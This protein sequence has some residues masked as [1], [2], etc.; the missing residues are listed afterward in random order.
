MMV[1]VR[2]WLSRLI[3]GNVAPSPSP[4]A[5]TAPPLAPSPRPSHNSGAF[6]G[7][8]SHYRPQSS[9]PQFQPYERS[10][11]QARAGDL[12]ANDWAASSAINAIATNAVG[13]GLKPQSRINA[14]RLGISRDDA[15]ELQD[16]IEA[17]WNAWTPTAHASGGL[18]FEDLQ[19]L[20]LRTLLKYG[21][22][23]HL[24]VMRVTP[25]PFS[26][27]SLTVQDVSPTRLRTPADR[28][29][30]PAIYDGIELSPTGQ[31]L[32]Y[33]LAT[34][35][36]SARYLDTAVLTSASFTR[37]PARIGHR[38]GCFHLFRA[39][40][41]EQKRG[42]PVLSSGL[43]LFRHLSDAVDHEL[44]AQVITASMTM[45]VEQ[46]DAALLPPYV[47]E[48]QSQDGEKIY[49][50]AV[51]PGTILYGNKNEKPHM[52]E[53]GRP[54]P[55]FASFCEL[56]MRAMAASVDMPYEVLS[57]DFSKT[58]Y[59]SARAAL[60]EAW[61]VFLLYRSWLTRHYCQPI[62][63][64]VIEEAWLRGLLTLPAGAPDFYDAIAAY[65]NALWIGPSRGYVDPVKEINAT[66]TA[67][68][69]RLMTYSEAIAE[70]GRDFD[71]VMDEREEEEARL[72]AIDGKTGGVGT[73][74]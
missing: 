5:T 71:E 16:N 13:T 24:P 42:T 53:A 35:P 60:L 51:E 49:H 11:S 14:K 26:P 54:S 23:L 46:A 30:D 22:L 20:G 59:S 17:I 52:L 18:H 36:S 55:N 64:M 12:T 69:N 25:A 65:T 62:Y 58:N 44:L 10:L 7:S 9:L 40:D 70:R 50:Q 67:L 33:W 47:Q 39:L 34:P 57:K 21:E 4:T 45:F 29:N 8:L 1:P 37:I 66:V 48:Q 56:I 15:L 41:D 28:N 19:F 6:R 27:L 61:R 31:P 74:P 43:N 73:G 2:A 63:N 72:D 32:A 3:G 38:Q 68:D